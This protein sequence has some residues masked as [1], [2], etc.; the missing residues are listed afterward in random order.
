M[1]FSTGERWRVKGVRVGMRGWWWL[2]W[3]HRKRK[4]KQKKKSN[5]SKTKSLMNI[6]PFLPAF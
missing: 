3:E 5:R 6:I 2:S 4:E 1:G